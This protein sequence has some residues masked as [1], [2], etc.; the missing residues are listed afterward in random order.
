MHSSPIETSDRASLEYKLPVGI[1]SVAT[2][3]YSSVSV[4]HAGVGASSKLTFKL[5]HSMKAGQQLM[6]TI[7]TILGLA[8]TLVACGDSSKVEKDDPGVAG[9]ASPQ[10]PKSDKG[11]PGLV[12]QDAYELGSTRRA[13]DRSSM[14][15]SKALTQAN[16]AHRSLGTP[17]AYLPGISDRRIPPFLPLGHVAN[18]IAIG[19]QE[20]DQRDFPIMRTDR[21]GFNNDDT[22][23]SFKERIL[24]VGDAY[25]QGSCVHQYEA[26]AAL[27]RRS[28]YPAATVGV[29][30][31][32]PIFAIATLAEYGERFKPKIV[33]WFHNQSATIPHL[34]DSE[35]RSAFLLQ[36]LRDGFTQNLVDRQTEIDAFLQNESWATNY[37][38]EDWDRKLDENLPL[39]QSLLGSDISSLRTDKELYLIFGRIIQIAKRR[40]ASWS[41]KMY[42]VM[43]PSSVHYQGQS[44]THR[45]PVLQEVRRAGLPIIDIDEA[46]RASGDPLQF[47][48]HPSR[49]GF[50]NPNGYREAVRRIMAKLEADAQ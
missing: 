12:V 29:G 1:V 49:Y 6:R 46:F 11:D 40:V 10:G 19:C 7:I 41:G 23:Y 39:V 38:E 28:G 25:A 16:I 3:A 8:L 18:T 24:V 2:F 15:V 34:H 47:F 4:G 30:G 35:L 27:L 37:K 42:F 33:L 22:V 17:A 48:P 32:G 43:V 50:F 44:P 13:D 14:D 36:Y 45:L 31:F 9:P 21:Y 20:G 5:D 26:A